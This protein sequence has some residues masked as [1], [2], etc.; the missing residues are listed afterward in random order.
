MKCVKND[1]TLVEIFQVFRIENVDNFGVVLDFFVSWNV[2]KVSLCKNY[3]SKR[4]QKSRIPLLNRGLKINRKIH[5]MFYRFPGEFKT[6]KFSITMPRAIPNT[7][8]EGYLKVI[9]KK[10]LKKKPRKNV[11]FSLFSMFRARLLH[12]F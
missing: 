7:F 2:Q 3:L 1:I 11:K 12:N 8:V 6:S 10:C 9:L 4:F 5:G